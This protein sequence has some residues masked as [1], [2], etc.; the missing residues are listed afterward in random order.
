MLIV[1]SISELKSAGFTRISLACGN[2]DGVHLG[3]KKILDTLLSASFK[4]KSK[5]VILT[6]DPHPREVLTG[7]VLPHLATLQT[8]AKLLEKAGIEAIINI[9][10]TKAFASKSANEFVETILQTSGMETCDICVGSDWHF[11]A[12]RE[13]DVAFLEKDIWPF[14]V[15]PVEE[16]ES[17]D[18]LISSSRI[19]KSLSKNNFMEAAKLLGRKYSVIGKTIKGQGIASKTLN[20]PTANVDVNGQCLPLAGVFIVSV[21]I[22]DQSKL[23]PAVC[24]IGTKPTFNDGEESVKVEVHLLDFSGDL[25]GSEIEIFFEEFVRSEQKF[26]NV[27]E[28]KEQICKDV[29]KAREF[30]ANQSISK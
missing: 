25:Y 1:S 4:S 17:G 15:Y 10:F 13:G 23:F 11:G 3:H 2:F 29:T 26:A 6:F 27:E 5:P 28:L 14:T 19:R 7:K 12:N 21:K 18:A 20:H 24:N 30:F 22:N 16:K 8:K 9:P